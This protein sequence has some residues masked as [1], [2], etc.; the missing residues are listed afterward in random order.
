MFEKL[1]MLVKTNAGMAVIDNPVIPVKHHDAVINEASSSIIE[2]LKAQMENG[3]LKDMVKYFQFPDIY[4]NN[5]PLISSAVNK[6]ANK[7]NNYYAI[8]PAAALTTAKALIK[9]VM[10]ELMQQSS[11]KNNDFALNKLLG[12][13]S[14]NNAT[15]M[16]ALLSQLSIA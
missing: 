12:S 1:F 2:V 16:D 8:E 9:P 3:K 6:F 13:L 15:G 10:Q 7:L 4:T 11:E 5:N 14:G